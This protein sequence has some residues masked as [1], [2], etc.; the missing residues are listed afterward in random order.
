MLFADDPNWRILSLL[1]SVPAGR[2]PN[3]MVLTAKGAVHGLVFNEKVFVFRLASS[4]THGHKRMGTVWNDL[5][6][7]DGDRQERRFGFRRQNRAHQSELVDNSRG[8]LGFGR[9]V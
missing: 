5:P 1:S 7:W 6:T 3:K 2:S 9:R 8:H 4:G